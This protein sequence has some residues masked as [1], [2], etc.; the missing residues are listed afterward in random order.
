MASSTLTFAIVK[1]SRCG[2]RTTIRISPGE[3]STRRMSN[4][5]SGGGLEPTSPTS[6]DPAATTPPTAAARRRTGTTAQSRQE[7][8]G[9]SSLRRPPSVVDLKE[10]HPAELGELGLVC[11]EHVQAGSRELDLEHTSLPL[12]LHDRVR[13]LPVLARAGRLVAEEVRVQVERVHEVELGQ[14]REVD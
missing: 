7:R 13:V 3:N 6:D 4:S 11:V 12:A 8:P 14:V 2:F 1:S 5:S 9:S 10:P